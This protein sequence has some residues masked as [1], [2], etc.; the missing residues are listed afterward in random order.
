MLVCPCATP[1]RVRPIIR[2]IICLFYKVL[3]G[4]PLPAAI[5][6]WVLPW[7]QLVHHQ[8]KFRVFREAANLKIQ[9]AHEF[10]H[11]GVVGQHQPFDVF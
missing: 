9:A 5:G 8:A 7:L 6:L 2:A 11:I 4:R 10:E 1:K 3:K